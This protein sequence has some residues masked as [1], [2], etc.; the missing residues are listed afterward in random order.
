M[1]ARI[2]ASAAGVTATFDAGAQ[3]V[4][5]LSDAAGP[6]AAIVLD[7]D[8]SGFLAALKLDAPSLTPG[9]EAIERPL[10]A[11]DRFDGVSSGA[12]EINGRY[13]AVDIERDSLRD[14]VAAIDAAN[15]GVDATLIGS[16]SEG[17][18][19]K[20]ASSQAPLTLADA[21]SGLLAALGIDARTYG[22]VSSAGGSPGEGDSGQVD[23][24]SRRRSYLIAD[25][26]EDMRKTFGKLLGEAGGATF[27]SALDAVLGD[28][29]ER[30]DVRELGRFGLDFSAATELF[31]LDRSE[32]R[33]FTR[34]VQLGD[35]RLFELML[36]GRGANE[37]GLI[38]TIRELVEAELSRRGGGSRLGNIVDAY[39]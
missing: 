36:E 39:A 15:A 18:R 32:R 5:L 20:L 6:A 10:A 8:T 38:E 22:S 25:G 1:L 28:V 29:L 14:V 37:A 35:E 17:F 11:L 33:R 24:A 16:A 31:D 26:L 19:V 21:G 27:G 30:F 3:T 4:E 12:I 7:D 34:A 13:I 23:R 9:E 2:D